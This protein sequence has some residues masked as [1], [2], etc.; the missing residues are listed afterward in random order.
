MCIHDSYSFWLEFQLQY[1]AGCNIS[2]YCNC[3][4]SVFAQARIASQFR[5]SRAGTNLSKKPIPGFEGSY[6]PAKISTATGFNQ[7]YFASSLS[8]WR[9]EFRLASWLTLSGPSVKIATGN[10]VRAS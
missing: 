1:Q 6:F 7:G 4:G 9:R 3:A 2:A 8:N 10:W 5:T